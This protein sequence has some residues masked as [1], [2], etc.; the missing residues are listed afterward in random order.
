MI[1]TLLSGPF[2]TRAEAAARGGLDATTLA[3]RQDVLRL[4][5]RHLEETYPAFQ[6][7]RGGLR[8]EIASIVGT[9]AP[10]WDQLSIADWLVRPSQELSALSPL[11]WLQA[12][13]SS[14]AVIDAAEQHHRWH[15]TPTVPAST[16]AALTATTSASRRFAQPGAIASPAPAV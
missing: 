3:S 14:Q 9:L 5:G 16:A 4:P 11:A 1:G 8:P 15:H 7:D 10:D 12:G 6:F 2:L 13:R